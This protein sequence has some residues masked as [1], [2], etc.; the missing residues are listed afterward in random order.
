[1]ADDD[2]IVEYL[3]RVTADLK[4]TRERVRELEAGAA[5]PIAVVAMGCRFPG[6]IASPE[7]LW[8][9]VRT[10]GDTISGF[11]TDRGWQTDHLRG[12]FRR[13]G[14]FLTDAGAFDAGLFGISP[15]EALAMDPQQRLL[16][17]TSWETLERAGLDPTALRGAD[18]GVFI[19]MAD[20][21]Y[22]PRGAE[23][24]DEVK[25]LVL[26]GTTSSVASGRI[27]YSLGLQGPAMTID[28]ACSSSLVALHL[29]VRALRSGECSFALVGGAAVLAESQLFAEMA[30]QGG[31]AGDGRCKAFA[32]AADGTG[33]GEGVGVLLLHRLSAARE[34]G[35]P[36]LATIRGT[37]VNQDG[38]SNGLTAPNGP[39]QRR[40]IRKALADAQ[41]S[42]GQVDAVEAHGTGTRLGDPIEAQ[43]LLATY[44][45]DRAG[46]E[47]LWLGS[48]KSN[49][50][51]T[52]AA[53]GIAGV[54][55]M[56]LAMRHGLL[57]RTL[58][59]DEPTPQVD[60][61]AGAVGLLTEE[62]DW[63]RTGRPRRSAVSSFGIS[64]TNAHVVLEHDPDADAAAP[65]PEP[66]SS[67]TAPVP[68]LVA[69][70]SEEALHAQAR[71]LHRSVTDAGQRPLDV[72][73]S[74]AAGRAR[75]AHRA[76]VVGA[77]REEL[78]AGLAAV[79]AG[80]AH[81]R[82]VRGRTAPTGPVAFLFTGQGSQR[83]GVG[84]EL[85]ETFP[86][87]ARAFDEVRERLDPQLAHPLDDI[88][89]G[90]VVDGL[91]LIEQTGYALAAVFALEVA[92]F[93]LV[94][95]A[96]VTPDF[97]LGHSTGELAAAHCA[98]VLSLDDACTLVA[99]RG[100]LV[101]T[102]RTDGAMVAVET[103]ETELAEL[104][105]LAD[106]GERATIAVVNGPRAVVVSGDADAV[107]RVRELCRE[108]G[109]K[110]R[111]LPIS[112]AAHSI[113]MEPMLE[114]LRK[115]AEGLEHHRP[116][117]PLVSNLTGAPVD[118]ESTNWPQYWVRQVRE[119]VRFHDGIHWLAARSVTACLE[120]GPGGALIAMAR[121]ALG[122][123][124]R[125][126]ALVPTLQH[127]RPEGAT[128]LTALAELHVH[129]V[130][131]AWETML[132]ARGGLRT[133]LPTY[134]FQRE[135]YWLSA[136]A[137]APRSG[138]PADETG[139]VRYQVGWTP[140]TGLDADARPSGPWLVVAPD[141]ADGPAVAAALGERAVLLTAG[142][143]GDRAA[144]AERIRAAL[145]AEQP[146]AG[147]LALSDTYGAPLTAALILR[148]ALGD[149]EVRAPLWYATRAAVSVDTE[150]AP[151]AAQSPLWGLGRLLHSA[152]GVLDLPA[153]LDARSLRLLGAVLAAP[154][155]SDE[156]AV[157]PAGV[158][159]RKLLPARRPRRTRDRRAAGTV[160]ITGDIAGVT[161]ELLR[162]LAV[163]GTREFVFAH[164]P[165][166]P[167]PDP[168]TLDAAGGP[169]TLTEWDP[170][171]GRE[172]V[173]PASVSAVV[174]L[175]GIDPAG[176]S[177]VD[178][179]PPADLAR[180]V[181]DRLRTVTRLEEL[182]LDADPDEFVLLSTVAGTWG[183]TEDV[184]HTLA[185]AALESLADRRA[186]AGRAGTCVGW[187][188]WATAT[189]PGTT[190]V[191]GLLPLPA[192]LAVS[193]LA[194][195]LDADEPV[196]A[197][198]DIDWARFHP[199]LTGRGPR[200]LVADLPA[201]RA[202]PVPAPAE[203]V[204][205]P[206]ADQEHRLLEMV[207]AQA[208]AVLGHASGD[209]IDPARP[210]RDLGFESLAAVRFRDR[211]AA[212][213][214]LRLPATLVFDHPTAQ[215]V[216]EHLL[217]ELS[218]THRAEDESAPTA[219]PDDPIAIVGMAC[220]YPG[221][222]RGPEDLWD[223]VHSGRDGVGDFPADRGWDLPALRRSE[224]GL[225]LKAGFLPDAA[226]FDAAFFGISPREAT[227]M[228]PQQ[229]LLLEVSWEALEGAG[230]APGA[231]RGSR[232]GVF[233]GAAGSD[234][235]EVLAGTPEADGYL[236]T[237]TAASVISG[238]IAY[239]LG[240]HGP[241]VTVDTACSSSLV[242]LHMA[243][244]ALHRGE[245]DL[246][247]ATGVSVISTPGAFVDFGRQNG[248]AGDGRCKAF[249]ATAD[250]TNWS[251]GVGI[252]VV[253]RLSDAQRNGHRVLATI[254]GSA[255]NSDGASNGLS[256]PNGGAQQRVI[257]QALATAGLSASDVDAVEA[258]GTGTTLGDPIEAQALLAT[259]GRDRSEE[260]PLWLGSLKS[261]IGHSGAAAGVGGVIKMVQA[262]RHGVLPQTLH[263]DRPTP[264]VDWSAG[265]VELLTDNRAWPET[266][267]PRRAGVSAFGV[268][269]TNAHIVL[270][271]GPLP[272]APAEERPAADPS[273]PLG[274]AAVPWLLSAR[275]PEAL[276]AQAER[277]AVQVA[278]REPS[279]AEVGHALLTSRS[280]FEQR[281]VVLGTERDALLDALR[282]VAAGRPA[283]GTVTGVARQ[284]GRGPVFVFPGQGGQWPGM[285]AELL[286][287]APEFAARWAECERALLPYTGFSVTELVRSGAPLDRVDVVQPVLFAVMVSLAALWRSH[288]VEP[289]AVAGHSQGEIAAACVSGALSLDDA[290]R[291]V[292]L[293]AKALL[294]LVGEGGMVSVG[295]PVAE[296]ERWL[297]RWDGR[298][299]VAAVNGPSAVVL[300]GE[301][302]ALDELMAHARA[303]D[304]RV[305]RIDVDYASHSAQVERIEDEILAA[306]G[307]VRPGPARIPFF[308]TVTADWQDTTGLDAAYWYR[309][310]REPVLLEP[311]VT[312]LAEQGYDVFVEVS[313]H[314]VL[315]AALTETAER[316]GADPV[317]T[318]T[319]RRDD[320]GLGRLRTALAELWAHGVPVDFTAA[321]EGHHGP[322]AELPAYPFQRVRY[323][324]AP[325]PAAANDP[326]DERFWQA[327]D[328]QDLPALAGT[329]GLADE[330]PLRTVVPALSAW[331]RGRREQ[332]VVDS[333]RYR[334][335]WRRLPEPE[336][337]ALPGTWLLVVPAGPTDDPA[338]TAV[339]AA[340]RERAHELVVLA[341][342]PVTDHI[343]LAA[344][345]R[346]ALD[347]TEP[348]GVVSLTAAAD[349]LY[350]DRPVAA[351]TAL[352][353]ALLRALPDASVSAPLWC[354]TH[355]AVATDDDAG[356][357]RP[358]QAA[359]WG[360]G[361]VA[362]LEFPHTWGG[363]VDLPDILDDRTADR[364]AAVLAG[365]DGEDQVAL[366]PSGLFGRRLLHA[367]PR[368]AA[369][370]GW[371]PHGTVLV[372]GG[373]GALGGRVARWL[374]R[375]GAAHLVLTSRRG[376][377]APGA[378]EL[379]AELGALGVRVSVLSCDLA[380]PEQTAAMVAEAQRDGDRIGA[381]V[382]T[383]GGGGLG[384][385][386]EAGPDDLAEAMAAKVAGIANLEAALDPAQLDAVVYFSSISA[387]W[388]AGNHGV[389]AA[390][391]TVLDARAEARSAADVYTVSLAW[392]P[393]AGG[394]MADDP[395]FDTLSRKGLPLID[396]D[397]AV[398]AL[399]AV[400]AEGESSLLLV[401]VDWALFTPQFTFERP[402][403][404]LLELPEARPEP[405]AD[406][407]PDGT[408]SPLAQRLAALTGPQRAA[409]LRELVREQA[410]T[411][412]GH[413]DARSVDPARPLKELG[414][415]SLTAVEL[416]NRLS[417][418]TGL[419]L[420]A[421]VVFD[422]PTIGELADVLARGL[423]TE[424][425]RPAAPATV[426]RVD[427]DEP[428][429]IVAMACRYPGGIASADDLWQAVRDEADLITPF[430]ADRGWDL[431]RLL[432][433][434]ADR[435]GASYV[436]HGGFLHDAA[437]FDPGFFGISPREAQATDPQHRLLLETT[438]EAL[439]RAGIAPKSL[440]GSRTGVYV[441][442]T[443]QAYGTRLR[444]ADDGMEGYLVS[445][446]ANVASGRISYSL[447][448]QG[449]ALT[450]DTACS[451]SLVALHLAAQA[452]RSGECDLAVAGGATVMPDPTSFV[453]FSRQRG[454]AENGRCKPF[455]AAADGF[456][457]GEGAG[458]LL[459][460]RLSDA[461]RNGHPVLAI[462]RGSAV[463]QDGASNGLTAPNGPAQER[464]IRQALVNAGLSAAEVDV[465][466]AH[467][468]GTTL[469]DP[470]EAQAL[471]A[472]YGQER[473]D[474]RPLWLGS[475]KSN[476]GHSQAAAGTAGVIKMVQAMRHGLMPRTLHVDAPSPHVDWTSG[477]V[478]LLVAARPWDRGAEPRRAAVS[479]FGISGTNAHIIL[480][481]AQAEPPV[482]TPAGTGLPVPL[483]LSARTRE[484]LPDQ[485][486]RLAALLEDGETEVTDLAYSLATTRGV[487]DRAAV[488][489][490][491]DRDEL[492]RILA[493]PAGPV[494]EERAEGGLAFLF[495]GQGAQR[496]GMGR[497]LYAAFPV[498]AAALDEVCEALDRHL[499]HPLRTVLFAEPGTPEA[500]RI[501]QTLYTQTS[502]FAV[503]VA[504]FR[505][506]EHWGVR[507]D[508]VLGHS[509]G[510][511][512]A[513]HVAGVWTTADAA[514]VVAAR[515]RLMQELP[516]GGAMLSVGAAED[517]VA[518]LLGD[519]FAEVAVAA[520]NGPA[521][522][523]LSGAEDAVTAAGARLA[524]AGLRTKRLTVSHA[525]HSPLMEPML[526]AYERELAGVAFAEPELPVI[527]DVTGEPAAPG[528][529]SDPAYWVR[530]VRQAVRFADGVRSLLD[531]G[532]TT[533]LELGP[534]GVLTAMAQESAGER[535][536]GIATQRR[537]R[538]QVR[539]LLTA[540]GRLHARTERV[541]W[542][543]FFSGTGARR[544][545]LPTYAFQHRRYW[546][547]APTGGA[548]ALIGAGLA[549]T[550]HPLL[551]AAVPL[552]H[553]GGSLFSGSLSGTGDDRSPA[554]GDVLDMVLWAGG[555]LGCDRIAA[556]DLDLDPAVHGAPHAP[557]QLVVTAP[558]DDGDRDFALHLGS[559]SR[560]TGEE[561]WTRIA[562]G[563][564]G[565]ASARPTSEPDPVGGE[566]E[567]VAELALTEQEAAD[568]DRHGLHPQLLAGL[569]DLIAELT[570]GEPVHFAGVTRYATGAA[571]LRAHL[572]R[573]GPDTVT[574]LLSDPA[575]EPVLAVDRVRV[576]Q[577]GSTGHQARPATAPAGL[578]RLTWTPVPATDPEPSAAWA[579]V[580]AAT[581]ALAKAL[582]DRGADVETHRDLASLDRSVDLVVLAVDTEPGDEPVEPVESVRHTAH[583]TL[584]QVKELLADGRTA[585]ARFV[586]VTRAAVSTGDATPVD[587]AQAAARGL[588]MS[589]QAEHPDRFVLA[590]LGAGEADAEL[591][592]AAVGT[593]LAE[594]E[595]QLAVRDGQLLVPRLARVTERPEP[596]GAPAP[597]SGTVLVTGASGGIGTEIV[598]HLASAHGVRRLLL[599][600]RKGADDPRAAQLVRELAESGAEAVFAAC[601]TADRAALAAVLAD[602]PAEHPVTAVVHI[603][604]VV[605]DGV[606]TTLT[607]ERV[608]T[609]LRPKVDAAQHLHEL[610][611]GLELSHFVLFSSGVGTFGGAGQANYAAANAFLDALAHRRRAAG[612][613]ATS[614]AWGLWETT[615]GMSADLSDVDRRRLAQSGVLALTPPQ[616][617]E[618]FDAAWHSDAATLVPMGLDPA[619]LR[620]K[621][622]DSTL[623][624]AFR[625]LVR[626]SLRRA[627]SA[628]ARTAGE[629]FAQQ[630]AGQSESGRRKLLLELI[631]RQVA[632][633]LNYSADAPFDLKLPFRELGFD[634]LTAV[635]LRNTL[636]AATGVQLSAALVFD[637]PT[638][639]ALAEHLEG[640]VLASVAGAPLP[641]LTQ[642]DQLEAAL[643]GGPAKAADREQI[644][645]RLRALAA[646]FGADE[647]TADAPDDSDITS[648]LDSATD[649]E[650]FDFINAELGED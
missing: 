350:P 496:V 524:E 235:G 220:R 399:A 34:A 458:V 132:A 573:S 546:L 368:P 510:E 18:G 533:F 300:S 588:L 327:V 513:A 424:P 302:A 643:A 361:R 117:I 365:L 178:D 329:L 562:S 495:T 460:E 231:L 102:L 360:L 228:D 409:A 195:A 509:V 445:A 3:K 232:T 23:Q 323:W 514:R 74:L 127:E 256:A 308:S 315:G 24:L 89:D 140:V 151:G 51:H 503:E 381:V 645:A 620:R 403:R 299:S 197:V 617:L 149:A 265:A 186:T 448:F 515:A 610:T 226:D 582:A 165:G 291:V 243:V 484:A 530:Q 87:F 83:A 640:K 451:S 561:S 414:F 334:V 391:N 263:V 363:L 455:A 147:V 389:Y 372:T 441:G 210:F 283:K 594:N 639:T 328:Q 437:L 542:A 494:A 636:I 188:P 47:P 36:V 556:L 353:L 575:G 114:G 214:G 534:D 647:R 552:P 461:R 518:A 238:R 349:D 247:L 540:L 474:G 12:D 633:V 607:P 383:A 17:E 27:A 505:L 462:V 230:L 463:N 444:G 402:S 354:L 500:A 431:D 432:D 330:Q 428:V 204:A 72:A 642:L 418:A 631:Q 434:D 134:A 504:L 385:L 258:H 543:A 30:E 547:D 206:S 345:V 420:P 85:Y 242:A 395:V 319:L 56:V 574:V 28:T 310:L 99:A 405:A 245:C 648:K 66:D 551:T 410:A 271:Q 219:A 417:T 104:M 427:Q 318:G 541:D 76:V 322:P 199:V 190:P 321:F 53:A 570:A 406:T 527:C 558:D 157:R 62:R 638:A 33:W 398:S 619:V 340:L 158:F 311:S 240:L 182:F 591:L 386:A 119:T 376:A 568:A 331:R 227:A 25:G 516:E 241:A 5:E 185:H 79:G 77:D 600:S 565:R 92:L 508:A 13:A 282:A 377:L 65:A 107:E 145:P 396:P 371:R 563:V 141:G 596:A 519:A 613:P 116:R 135:R 517:E 447:G 276:R 49:I 336:P 487:L 184:V 229:R 202:L 139:R 21:K 63:P 499:P 478:E 535:A 392:A 404:L 285:A 422:H 576:R 257:R 579:V 313:P 213:T 234:Y 261:N 128:F 96:G 94:E 45:Q 625:G 439:E 39:A 400:L 273:A 523:V 532:V 100:R 485:A 131:V 138:E 160:L 173:D 531:E 627:A 251:E 480:E 20:Q 162:F 155:D 605:D 40:V 218:G 614:L 411:V 98:G 293:R 236:T 203:A 209:A 8:E 101:Q 43:A 467:G 602:V 144:L 295:V 112:H 436:D 284:A 459:V 320:G 491:A 105:A 529:L 174:H 604:G 29:A 464:V 57:P 163:D 333:W 564:L 382:H 435:Q 641:V 169:Y 470:I 279:V 264:E 216:A 550:G 221:G 6:G 457:L 172:P 68:W 274:R 326:Q 415:D 208:A 41:L 586:F 468:T 429:A 590:D 362:A 482:E 60:W 426:V 316:A 549:G 390:A 341:V 115:V 421:T 289:A 252:L 187:G 554:V 358:E 4:R 501:D 560:G 59:V 346:G 118:P 483:V 78:L 557:L 601:D 103:S 618:L 416:R 93:R 438:W 198:A 167:L 303:Q 629:S 277:L 168:G 585:G 475:V 54:I 623:P 70:A 292:A 324:P 170:D 603:A 473:P 44:G 369:D 566:G 11:P 317:V 237:G 35:L 84:R 133:E 498:F 125:D 270:E 281:A 314:P 249:A 201:V 599:L 64:G 75:L 493:D 569:T 525:F 545:D 453:A 373:T 215:E 520:V 343:A 153:D 548:Q 275:T 621:A 129:G 581:D 536:T 497:E 446:S 465:V 2:K 577:G 88:I 7:D 544:V 538:D 486:A 521:A 305:R 90:R 183:G 260:R 288:G 359:V 137:T 593:A 364:L 181:E 370:A 375:E 397:L 200:P 646:A 161:P 61:S 630:L 180:A 452:L 146:V 194:E 443:D 69:A 644:A 233:A 176:P 268:S 635:E 506:L 280:D 433:A 357:A 476:I 272:A 337:R 113:H 189:D 367:T 207:R 567:L 97:V 553:T 31:M 278:E 159:A 212:E 628:G 82:V 393:W 191:P 611:A 42:V 347:G 50:G 595:P 259:Y 606:L 338:V 413:D 626:A 91:P 348:A 267:R 425:A 624:A 239:T 150:S 32:A 649:E 335:G 143:D 511:L 166:A 111:R 95:H 572:T 332:A 286:D 616:G 522:T 342:D 442:M 55:K 287:T 121:D 380:D 339:T 423:D 152:G 136:T 109:R 52:Q 589:A 15:R 477:A 106:V 1:M 196:H 344:A 86:V 290:A 179:L 130:S 502:L 298:I 387:S 634:S 528:Q 58:H 512:A 526:A 148:Q 171:S 407:A 294:A 22:G 378:D 296:A 384:P 266:G 454:L 466:E 555:G 301:P 356:P 608:D 592:A 456:S 419:K 19:G 73:W 192:R 449:P 217:A 650:L 9:V 304:V 244:G 401:D 71:R 481:E 609:V 598:R 488:V 262:M 539:T 26:T 67:P 253:E 472:T 223:L 632:A 224:P 490:A 412:L 312:G 559:G 246:A 142:P 597:A 580:G 578:Y 507:P 122:E 255:I 81:P 325:R 352:S 615:A 80:Q 355:G 211:I 48:V 16:L 110:T 126:V 584:E 175:S 408:A 108:R 450:V 637:H 374:A 156:L 306:L 622:A 177:A 571:E 492:R 269:G 248:L 37:A 612:L 120:L 388:G 394:G 250:G 193:A 225:A 14:G 205:A 379:A 164:R 537:D 366:R 489:V 46:T 309:N 254:R 10:G 471:L 297:P 154:G 440:H 351:G 583:R 307:P 479:G 38:A 469:G 222:V 430:P 587:P 124:G 123:S